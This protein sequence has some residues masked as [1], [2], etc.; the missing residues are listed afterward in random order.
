MAGESIA[1]KSVVTERRLVAVPERR[2]VSAQRGLSAQL[3]LMTV[4]FVFLGE[5]LIFIPSVAAE[6]RAYLDARIRDAD[7]ATV[8]LEETPNNMVSEQLARR[9]LDI[10]GVR[11]IVYRSGQTRRLVLA[12]ALPQSLDFTYDLRQV[13]W[14]GGLADAFET[15]LQD[16]NRVMRLIGPS[17]QSEGALVEVVMDEAPMAAQLR[18]VSS[19]VLPGPGPHPRTPKARRRANATVIFF[20]INSFQPDAILH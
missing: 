20:I 2:S 19:G 10:A 15:L 16:D 4:A 5:A 3:L 14:L 1:A 11:A 13:T 9:L 17:R 8:S 18:A 6:R 12:E 7:L